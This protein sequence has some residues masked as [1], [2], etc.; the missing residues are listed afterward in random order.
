MCAQITI[1]WKLHQL[2]VTWFSF[3]GS[4][5]TVD[6]VTTKYLVMQCYFLYL[7]YLCPQSEVSLQSACSNHIP[8][9]FLS[10]TTP[11]SRLW[12]FLFQLPPLTSLSFSLCASAFSLLQPKPP[13]SSESK[14]RPSSGA[15]RHVP[16]KACWTL[17]TSAPGTNP[18]WQPWSTPSRMFSNIT[19]NT[20]YSTD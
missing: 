13:H 19:L 3:C 16:C 17:T 14:P 11:L 9:V 4:V 18:L 10:L 7:L 15:C 1:R 20:W 12:L 6:F 2:I 5:W 8:A